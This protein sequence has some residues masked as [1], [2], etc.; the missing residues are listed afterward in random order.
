M[1]DDGQPKKKAWVMLN[2]FIRSE[3]LYP[4][5]VIMGILFL[6]FCG[7]LGWCWNTFQG[8]RRFRRFFLGGLAVLAVFFF[9]AMVFT[10]APDHDEVEHASAAWQMSQ[11]LLPF[12]DFFQHHSPM[13]WILLSPL[14]K[15]PVISNYPVESVRLISA[16]VSL[17]VLLL[18]ILMAKSI[19]KDGRVAWVVILF[20]LGN[21]LTLQLFNLRPDL[22]AN[23]CNLSAFLIIMRRR[24]IA[25]YA[26][27]GFLL[28]FSFSLS[29]KYL[30]YLLLLPAL[31]IFDRRGL[32]F[33]LRALPAHAAGICIGL[34]PLFAWLWSHGLWGPFY[35]WVIVFNAGRIAGGAT[36]LGGKFQLIPTGFGLWGCCRLLGSKDAEA[37]NHGRLLCILMGL[38]ALVYLKSS[39]THNEYYEQMYILSAVPATAGPFLDLLKKWFDARRTVLAFLLVGVVLWSGIHIA[40]N[41]LRHGYYGRVKGS[42]ETLRRIAGRDEVICTTPEH[43]ITSRN[44]VYISTNWQYVFCLSNPGI[45]EK[46]RHVVPDIQTKK[47][48]VIINRVH[49]WPEDWDFIEHLQNQGIL[50]K[51]EAGVLRNYLETH[52]RLIRIRN[53]EYWIRNDRYGIIGK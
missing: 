26:L 39:R 37:V 32:S 36:L 8:S 16:A 27:A 33:Y 7:L 6:G 4:T 1:P 14:F 51:D 52:Y 44:A 48:A 28:G 50:S 30:P 2:V 24:K 34:L 46:M 19:W 22:L 45:R 43:P 41:Y 9:A 15:I 21:F 53:L 40:Q 47:P 3:L 11:G 5:A 25:A 29:P 42:I 17:I 23:L 49:A 18:L 13:L 10:Y 35:Q 20:F 12:N 31:M 38:S